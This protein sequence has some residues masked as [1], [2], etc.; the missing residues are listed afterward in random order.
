MYVSYVLDQDM[1]N[2]A[3][4]ESVRPPAQSLNYVTMCQIHKMFLLQVNIYKQCSLQS[5]CL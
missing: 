5:S 4:Q 2:T 3:I 1:G